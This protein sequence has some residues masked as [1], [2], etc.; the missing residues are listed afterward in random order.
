[1]SRRAAAVTQA[2]I[3]RCGRAAKQLGPEWYIEVDAATGTI[4]MKQSASAPGGLSPQSTE[5]SCSVPVAE[6][7][8]WR[9]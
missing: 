1:V 8:D 4:R 3:S 2:D 9:L 5:R 6:V 7:K